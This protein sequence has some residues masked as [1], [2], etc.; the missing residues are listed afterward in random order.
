MAFPVKSS[1]LSHSSTQVSCQLTRCTEIFIFPFYLFPKFSLRHPLPPLP[2]LIFS[3]VPIFITFLFIPPIF[4]VLFYF[5]LMFSPFL[6]D[7]LHELS[8]AD[9]FPPP[10]L[11]AFL[12]SS[13]SVV[14]ETCVRVLKGEKARCVVHIYMY[15][16]MPVCINVNEWAFTFSLGRN[17]EDHQRE[18]Q[19]RVSLRG[20][21]HEKNKKIG[22]ILRKS[23]AATKPWLGRKEDPCQGDLQRIRIIIQTLHLF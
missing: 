22:A 23:R 12:F 3:F 14:T 1:L 18:E 10:T 19:C 6:G 20:H 15:T 9:R 2:V 7:L 13:F 11:I 8:P 16:Y 21:A 5:V 17:Q 4:S